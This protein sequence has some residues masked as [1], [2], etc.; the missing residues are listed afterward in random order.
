M[1]RHK[2]SFI[3]DIVDVASKLPWWAGVLMALVSYAVLHSY[4]SSPV[5]T[6]AGPGQMGSFMVKS[7]TKTLALFGQF[8][9]P[10][11]FLL[12][13]LVSFINARKQNK[14]YENVASAQKVGALG[15]MSWKEFEM[16]VSEFFRRRGFSTSLTGDGADGGVDIVLKKDSEKYLVQC[17]QWKAY[18]VGV[19]QVRELYG[20]MAAE[21]ATGGYFITSGEYTS[22]ARKF[23]EGKNIRLVDGQ[24]LMS[25]I[26]EVR[27]SSPSTVNNTALKTNSVIVPAC[28]KCGSSMIKRIARKGGNAGNEFWGCSGYPKC[29][30][31]R[32]LES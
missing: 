13:A 5:S 28:P 18:K 12:G 2:N 10:F 9:L 4:A 22:E 16:M 19:P 6:L 32:A 3:E 20:V 29:H 17:K 1:A 24:K 14:L 7:L 27:Q 25:M 31:I 26:K 8:V 21:C 23:S 11:A 30:G 15:E